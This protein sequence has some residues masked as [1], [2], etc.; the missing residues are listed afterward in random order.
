VFP[1]RK[2]VLVLISCVCVTEG[3]PQFIKRAVALFQAQTH[4]DKELLIMDSFYNPSVSVPSSLDPA[5]VY[6]RCPNYSQGKRLSVGMHMAS[7]KLLQKWDDDDLY[8]PGFLA[9]VVKRHTDNNT[10]S[11]LRKCLIVTKDGELRTRSGRFVGGSVTLDRQA[12]NAI[13]G[14]SD[15]PKDVD[16]DV[17]RRCANAGVKFNPQHEYFD[18][19]AYVRH[20]NNT[21]NGMQSR[22][23][24]DGNVEHITLDEHWQGLP[25]YD[26]EKRTEV[27]EWLQR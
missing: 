23:A 7:G 13:G 22:Q 19:Y 9:E 18:Q 5:I 15:I 11:Y 4:Q 20:E 16:G 25:V 24:S 6:I 17:F 14:I 8:L 12:F 1:V 27:L 10:V 26:G 3:R 2:D 21:W